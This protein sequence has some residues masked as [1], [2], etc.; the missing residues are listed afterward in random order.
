MYFLITIDPAEAD[1]ILSGQ[2]RWIY[3][4]SFPYHFSAQQ[5]ILYV[6][7]RH[8]ILGVFTIRGVS[9]SR[10]YAAWNHT[11]DGNEALW[12]HTQEGSGMTHD[13]FMAWAQTVQTG[14]ITAIH[15]DEWRE[16]VNKF[17]P[18]SNP[19]FHAPA[20]HTTIHNKEAEWMIKTGMQHA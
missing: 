20:T 16:F 5:A 15:L 19:L 4:K 2:K 13:E 9:T 12:N 6:R 3:R 18:T 7:K 8:I 11:D 17:D 14:D 1:A 10:I